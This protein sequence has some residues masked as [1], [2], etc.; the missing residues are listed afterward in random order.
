MTTKKDPSEWYPNGRARKSKV[1]KDHTN[2][3]RFAPGNKAAAKKNRKKPKDM[4]IA[5]Y[6]KRE[7]N[8]GQLIIDAA[9]K[10]LRTRDSKPRE[11]LDA[12]K[13]LAEKGYGKTPVKTDSYI[14]SEITFKWQ[15]EDED[16]E[17]EE[18]DG[19]QQGQE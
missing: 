19:D 9:L 5:E 2:K 12:C 4:S 10:V 3:G 18:V 14:E 17:Y 1:S 6:I 15:G 13:F 7:T 8:D 16:N 11:I